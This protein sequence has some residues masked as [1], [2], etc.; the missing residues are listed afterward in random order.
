MFT[1]VICFGLFHGLCFLPVVL[2]LVGPLPN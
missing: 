2:S 1:V